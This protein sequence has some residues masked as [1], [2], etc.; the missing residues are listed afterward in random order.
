MRIEPFV[1]GEKGERIFGIVEKP[2]VGSKFPVVIM[3]HGFTGEHISSFFKL[4]R[5]S[6]KLS[7]NGIAVVRFDF[8]GSGN[9]DG[10]F[11]DMTP[12][13]EAADAL[14][15][16]EMVK[17]SDW[18]N[19]NMG[20]LGYSLGGVITSLVAAR[21]EDL[22]SVC[23]WSPGIINGAEVFN[24]FLA[25]A[26]AKKLENQ[27]LYDLG[28]LLVSEKFVEEIN[29][30][31]SQKLLGMYKGPVQIVTGTNDEFVNFHDANEFA[32]SRNYIFNGV[33]G[34]NHRYDKLEHFNNL[35]RNTTDF[36]EKTLIN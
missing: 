7:E 14:R 1:L 25:F 28:S 11:K 21:I 24:K 3:L 36:F 31:D 19:G 9:S 2:D 13:S 34:A 20:L 5:V 8:C 22:K 18:F 29:S 35:S 15:V 23:L 33:E 27:P 4:P 17:K 16:V 10:D 12:S 6:R 26:G 32:K 30:I